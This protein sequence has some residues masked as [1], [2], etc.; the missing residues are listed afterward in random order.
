MKEVRFIVWLWFGLFFFFLVLFFW[1]FFLVFV[2]FFFFFFF[3]CEISLGV[4][5][6]NFAD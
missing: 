4:G 5:G 6:L 1:F 2:G 3:C